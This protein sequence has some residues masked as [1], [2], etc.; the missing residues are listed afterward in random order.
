MT[1]VRIKYLVHNRLASECVY[2]CVCVCVRACVCFFLRTRGMAFGSC[3]VKRAELEAA[4]EHAAGVAAAAKAAWT[5]E[6][7]EAAAAAADYEREA[8]EAVRVAH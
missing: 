6:A 4:A 3:R 7:A 5:K 2:V 1:S 8:A